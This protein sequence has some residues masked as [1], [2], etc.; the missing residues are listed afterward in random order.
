MEAEPRQPDDTLIL[1]FVLDG[2]MYALEQRNGLSQEQT[3]NLLK[4][5]FPDVKIVP[6]HVYRNRRFDWKQ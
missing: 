2:V 4:D 5:S 6:E 1:H 3:W